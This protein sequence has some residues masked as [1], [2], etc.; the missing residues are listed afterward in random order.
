[1]VVQREAAFR[2][3]RGLHL[4]LHA[5]HVD[6]GRA[7]A[8]AGL[9]RDA[10]RHRLRHLIRCERAGTELACDRKA[11]RIG[12]AARDVALVAGDAI[13]RAH[14]AAGGFAA[15]AVVV[16]HLDGALEPAAGAGPGRPI[17]TSSYVLAAIVRFEAEQRAVVEFR[18]PHHLARIVE[19]VRIET[20]L[21]FLE[22][23]RQP[24]PEH[25]LVELGAQKT[26]AVLAGMRALVFAHHR[27]R[28]F[29]DGAHRVHILLKPQIEDRPDVQAAGA[30]MRVPGAARAMLLEDAGQPRR[31]VGEMLERHRA[32]L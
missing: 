3:A 7:F 5:R 31:V 22:G 24:R 26:I 30:G 6:A 25:R 28:L 29:G 16:A 11:Q 8:A 20:I 14:H 9:A 13:G 18:R 17:E 1:P 10:E 32:I 23:P 2:R 12:A 4:D 27:E 19:P 15:G 21:Y